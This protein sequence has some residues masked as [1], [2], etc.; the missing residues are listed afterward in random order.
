VA[1]AFPPLIGWSAA[2][3]RVSTLGWILFGILFLWQIPHFMAIAWMYREDYVT[4][5]FPMLPVRDETGGK[6][7]AYALTASILLVLL[8]LLPVALHLDSIWYAAAAG[9]SGAWLIR[10]A[11]GFLRP[12]TR[13]FGA[14]QLFLASIAYLPIAL[15]ALVADRLIFY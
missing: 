7:A 5:R 15:G 2:Q 4:V 11:A 14:R 8:T 9:G 10:R 13:G 3:G 12:E 1:G 6:V